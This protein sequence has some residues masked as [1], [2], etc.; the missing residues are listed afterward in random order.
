VT[1]VLMLLANGCDLSVLVRCTPH[2]EATVTRWLERMGRHSQRL[3]GRFFQKLVF[4]LLQLDEL[5][6]R[7]RREGVQWVWVALDPVTKVIPTL[8]LGSRITEAAMQFVHQVAQVLAPNCLPA[9]TTDGLRAYFYALSAHFGQWMQEPG[10]RKAHWQVSP[11]LL[12]GQLV[13]RNGQGQFA[14]MR[15]AWGT[16]AALAA[17]LKAQGFKMLIQTAF[18]ERV[19][20]TLRRG[21]APLMRKTWAYAQTVVH[22]HLP[23]EWWRVYYH[24]VRPHESL[25]RKVPGLDRQRHQSPAMAAGLTGRLWTVKEL[26]YLPLWP[27]LA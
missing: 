17:V 4:P 6:A 2:A 19:N 15:M 12:H 16:R 20:L 18:V 27:A 11:D 14:A 25:G 8:Y 24:Y 23:L 9:F 3:H 1:L 10:Q 22:L 7:V 13:K 21:V 26:L 5:H